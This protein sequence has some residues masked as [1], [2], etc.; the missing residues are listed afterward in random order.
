MGLGYVPTGSV[1]TE[2]DRSDLPGRQYRGAG[3]GRHDLKA[4]G[5]AG[6]WIAAR[7]LE[8]QGA[9]ILARNLTLPAGEIDLLVAF[10]WE[11]AAVEVKSGT[12]DPSDAFTDRKVHHVW[13]LAA[14]LEPPVLRVDLV[15]VTIGAAVTVR[16][17]PRAG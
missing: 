15:A 8:H 13:D 11:R 5:R 12:Q 6:E 7:F 14:S 10:G 3:A 4:L 2:R 16:W 17:I 1:S 9:R